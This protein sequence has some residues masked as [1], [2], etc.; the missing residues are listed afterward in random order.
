MGTVVLLPNGD[1]FHLQDNPATCRFFGLEP[2]S[3]VGRSARGLG[4]P[5]EIISLW[6]RHYEEAGAKNTSV[7][8]EYT[9]H[10]ANEDIILNITVGAIG[11]DAPG[12][13]PCYG[14][15]AQD[16]TEARAGEFGVLESEVG[17]SLSG[18]RSAPASL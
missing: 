14:Y 4:V 15:L 10:L 13:H 12:G 1:I 6:R 18:A 11:L 5:E 16:V 3:T 8:F 17:F 7:S 9:H 2:G